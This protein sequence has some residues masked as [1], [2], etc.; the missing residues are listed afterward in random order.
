[1]RAAWIVVVSA[2][3]LAAGR[4]HA[5]EPQPE[6]PPDIVKRAAKALE[7]GRYEEAR[8]LFITAYSLTPQPK[9]LFALGQV[10]FN[11]ENFPAAVDYYQKFLDSNPEPREAALAQQAIGAARAR[12]AAPPPRVIEKEMPAPTFERDWDGW[13]TSLVVVGGAAAIAGAVVLIHGYRMGREVRTM[14]TARLYGDRLER[15]KR[16]QWTGLGVASAGTL[17]ATAALVRFAVHR[18]EVAP[19]A[20]PETVGLVVGHAW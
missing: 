15:S 5:E 8:G 7:E 20:S 2:L 13:N 9:I 6:G 1:V 10:E 19:I 3:A 4:A 12:L 11:L 16:W 14:E 17:I 18:V